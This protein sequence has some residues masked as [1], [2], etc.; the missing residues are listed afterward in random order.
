MP[1]IET[2]PT[3]NNLDRKMR[4]MSLAEAVAIALEQGTRRPAQLAVPRHRPG[5]PGA[6]H[7][8][9]AVHLA[10]DAIRVL[11]LDP[12]ASGPTSR[13]RCPSSTPSSPPACTGRPPTSPS[14]RRCRRSSPAAVTAISQTDATFNARPAQAAADRRRGRHHVQRPYQFT[15]LPAARQPVVPAELQ[16]QFEQPLLQG[17]GVEI[18]QLRASAPR[19]PAQPRRA[20]PDRPTDAKAS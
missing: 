20:Q 6:V 15:N 18:N 17:F 5:Q 11:A 2:P 10:S 19:Q 4:F 7:R 14:A 8:R 12:A 16:F 9:E 1:Q 13:R 3:L